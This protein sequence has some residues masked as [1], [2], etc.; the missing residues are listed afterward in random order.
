MQLLSSLSALTTCAVSWNRENRR[1]KEEKLI[2]I[3]DELKYI[4]LRSP[5]RFFN[6]GDT[7]KIYTL[8]KEK[9]KILK[10]KEIEDTKEHSSLA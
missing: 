3:E 9:D 2:E 1:M 5:T 10:G 6:E 8:S 4:S 7:Q